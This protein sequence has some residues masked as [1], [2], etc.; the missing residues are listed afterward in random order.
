[1]KNS[2]FTTVLPTNFKNFLP[3]RSAKKFVGWRKNSA[4][5]PEVN[6]VDFFTT[7]HNAIW[8]EKN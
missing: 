7:M 4:L 3:C 6:I 2:Y 5:S 1:M 8:L